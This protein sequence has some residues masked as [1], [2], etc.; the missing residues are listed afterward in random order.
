MTENKKDLKQISKTTI[1][2]MVTVTS[3]SAASFAGCCSCG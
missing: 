2:V 1:D 3:D